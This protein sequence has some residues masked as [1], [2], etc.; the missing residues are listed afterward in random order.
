MKVYSQPIF[1]NASQN[2]LV[3]NAGILAFA[4]ASCGNFW[5]FL[6]LGVNTLGTRPD[7]RWYPHQCDASFSAKRSICNSIFAPLMFSLA[8]ALPAY[9]C[10][11]RSAKPCFNTASLIYGLGGMALTM[12]IDGSTNQTL[13]LSKAPLTSGQT[14]EVW[15]AYSEIWKFWNVIRICAAALTLMLAGAGLLALT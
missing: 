13:A 12:V 8:S 1:A 3:I 9:I 14:S 10:H 5:L 11:K 6:G 2:M 15:I 4:C 7:R